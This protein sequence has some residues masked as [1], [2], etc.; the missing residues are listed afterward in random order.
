MRQKLIILSLIDLVFAR[1]AAERTL[2][3]DE[4]AQ[5]TRLELDEV[6]NPTAT[7]PYTFVMVCVSVCL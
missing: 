6:H 1:P 2:S 7:L 4:I 3:F 5:R